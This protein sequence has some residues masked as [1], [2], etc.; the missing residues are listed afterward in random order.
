MNLEWWQMALWIVGSFGLG[1]GLA[2]RSNRKGLRKLDEK[3]SRLSER[4][5]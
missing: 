4:L 2:E 1:W 3:I 5:R